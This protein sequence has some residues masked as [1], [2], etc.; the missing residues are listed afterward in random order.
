MAKEESNISKRIMLKLSESCRIFRNNVG[1]F[2][3][4]TGAKVKTGLCKGSSDLIGWHTVEITPDMIGKK[5][6]IF[7]AVE[8]KSAKGRAS[9]QQLNFIDKVKEAG[10]IAFIARSDSEAQ[11]KLNA[12]IKEFQDAR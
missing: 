11:N 2:T 8:V 12:R 6:G 7:L 4:N 3:T 5:I 9:E 10:G 1:L